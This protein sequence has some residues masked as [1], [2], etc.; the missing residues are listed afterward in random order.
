MAITIREFDGGH[1]ERAVL[2]GLVTSAPVLARVAS[3]WTGDLFATPWANLVAGWCVSYYRRY[4]GAPGAAITS[5]FRVWAESAQDQAAVRLVEEFLVGLSDE[6]AQS[7]ANP[8]RLV[9][10][11][12]DHF[13]RVRLERTAA[14][15][16]AALQF[17][18]TAK[19]VE[20][21]SGWRRVDIGAGGYVDPLEDPSLFAATLWQNEDGGNTLIEFPGDLGEFYANHFE[22]NALVAFTAPEKTGKSFHLLDLAYTAVSQ[23]RRVAFFSVGDMTETQVLGRLAARVVGRP[24]RSATGW[25]C[26]IRVP[27]AIEAPEYGSGELPTVRYDEIDCA[28]PLTLPAVVTAA[29]RFMA[30]VVKSRRSF[31]RL[32]CY[33]A[34]AI[35]VAGIKSLLE[36]WEAAD[37]WAADLVFIDYADVLAPPSEKP[38]FRHQVNAV[39]EALSA[40][41]SERH[42]CVVTATQANRESYDA[43]LLGR[44]HASEDK[45]KNA[46]VTAM[47]G[48]N[49]TDDEREAGLCRVNVLE[50]RE[51]LFH[52]RRVLHVAGCLAVARPYVVATFGRPPRTPPDREDDLD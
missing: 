28:D 41:R 17:G 43:R 34:R 7:A 14:R 16:Q 2:A 12:G 11:A 35:G 36:E 26:R 47:F 37:G 9:D 22:R 8:E 19:A 42:I 24:F 5:I 48:I 45:R 18:D 38:D 1:R 25:P 20:A 13:T 33:P 6:H 27:N 3:R 10:L 21:A 31:F 44:R 29:N 51:G 30:D 4:G 15:V 52:S 32:C 46:H 50:L 23:R 40:L 49:V 39:W